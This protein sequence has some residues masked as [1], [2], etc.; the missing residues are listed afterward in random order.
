[1]CVFVRLA[2]V[3]SP[4]PIQLIHHAKDSSAPRT[5]WSP[6]HSASFLKL[7]LSSLWVQ[8]P[9]KCSSMNV[10]VWHLNDTERNSEEIK[11]GMNLSVPAAHVCVNTP[12]NKRS[13]DETPSDC[14]SAPRQLNGADGVSRLSIWGLTLLKTSVLVAWLFFRPLALLCV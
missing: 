12:F 6:N 1:M 9:S 8:N 11:S 2:T 7:C 4:L 13:C 10:W 3:V 14:D 5:M